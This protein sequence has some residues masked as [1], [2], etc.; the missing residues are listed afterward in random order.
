MALGNDI[1][2]LFID[3]EET[4]GA[5]G[6]A[7]IQGHGLRRS[8]ILEGREAGAGRHTSVLLEVTDVL[9]SGRGT[10]GGGRAVAR[11]VGAGGRTRATSGGGSGWVSRTTISRGRTGA[12]SWA[13]AA[14]LRVHVVRTAR[15]G[16][17]VRTAWRRAIFRSLRVHVVRVARRGR[18]TAAGSHWHSAST[19][20]HTAASAHRHHTSSRHVGRSSTVGEL[21]TKSAAGAT[22]GDDR[23]ETHFVVFPF[24]VIRTSGCKKNDLS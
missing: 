1:D 17:R 16:G 21:Q 6:C 13:T 15:R 14:I 20:G 23:G 7:Q 4:A 18:R 5:A 9:G 8:N 12:T 2:L 24:P 19:H 10:R 3:T 11:A 22:E